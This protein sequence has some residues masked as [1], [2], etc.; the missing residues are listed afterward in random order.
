MAGHSKWANIKRAKGANDAKR[1]AVF[2]R[3]SKEITVAA[4]LGESGDLNFNPMLRVSV[5]KAKAA[6]MPNERIQKAINKG[7]GVNDGSESL[8][9][10]TYEAYAPHGVAMLIDVETDNANRTITDIKTYVSKND[11]KMS[12]EG[13]ISWQFNEIGYIEV[14]IITATD[15]EELALELL[16]LEG[17]NDLKTIETEEFKGLALYTVK[18]SLKQLSDIIREKF[19]N[20]LELKTAKLIKHSNTP[21][22]LNETQE[23]EVE[24][25]ISGLEE[26]PDI[27]EIWTNLA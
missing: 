18:E 24:E 2:N 23:Q 1:S 6:N 26:I 5:D 13:S 14:S 17:I 20:I 12:N 10:N 8:I 19:K 25:F 15:P 4:R 7:V 3:I 16:D 21:L 9:E 11:G 27:T 22:K